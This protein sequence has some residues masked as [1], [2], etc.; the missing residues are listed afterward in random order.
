[1]YFTSGIL[2]GGRKLLLVMWTEGWLGKGNSDEDVKGEEV[3]DAICVGLL[4]EELERGRDFLESES[5]IQKSMRPSCCVV[6]EET[7][8]SSIRFLLTK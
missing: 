2:R 4:K 1:M 8:E 5:F 6:L 3:R 7:S